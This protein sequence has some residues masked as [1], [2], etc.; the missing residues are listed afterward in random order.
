MLRVVFTLLGILAV[1]AAAGQAEDRELT[2]HSGG[3]FQ[4]K[5]ESQLARGFRPIDMAMFT[6]KQVSR[7]VVI[8]AARQQ[9]DF[10]VL[11][12][13]PA[14]QLQG[15]TAEHRAK[16]FRMVRLAADRAGP[17]FHFSGL[18]EK[19]EESVHVRVGF[20]AEKFETEQQQ[21][22]KEGCCPLNLTVTSVNG[23]EYYSCLWDVIG[24]PKRELERG[25]TQL[26][27]TRSIPKRA[28]D[29]FRIRQVCGYAVGKADRY[30]CVWEKS[31]GP[32]R[33]VTIR[34]T[35]TGLTRSLKRMQAKGLQPD[36]IS[37]YPA[38][39]QTRFAVVWQAE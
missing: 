17:G 6:E 39:G 22:F 26:E 33:Q 23:K 25:L 15:K 2:F 34:Q 3:D 12:G 37:V 16:G 29:G 5:Y 19:R 8:W 24:E 9:P 38:G 32:E 11:I 35:A 28:K 30:A 20:A 21:L 7:L 14:D 27:V 36:R 31:Q 10:V 18:W 4:K 1:A 13:V